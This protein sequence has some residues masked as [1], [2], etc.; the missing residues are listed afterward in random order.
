MGD[1][2]V[3]AEWD[4]ILFQPA[5]NYLAYELKSDIMYVQRVTMLKEQ[6]ID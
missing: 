5:D 1:F 6:D 2:F 4:E 3:G